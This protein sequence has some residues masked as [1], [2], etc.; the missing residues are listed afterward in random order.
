MQRRYQTKYGKDPFSDNAI[1]RWLKQFH[2]TD[3]V[4]CR[5]EAGR[6]RTSQKVVDRIQEA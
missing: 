4:L 3:N 5:K 2:E 1:R 6:P